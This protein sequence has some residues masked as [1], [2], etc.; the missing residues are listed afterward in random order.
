MKNA[1]YRPQSA[2]LLPRRTLDSAL[3]FALTGSCLTAAG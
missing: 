1:L 2:Q 3:A